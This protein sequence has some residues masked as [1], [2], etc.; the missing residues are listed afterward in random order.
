M[1]TKNPQ[2]HPSASIVPHDEKQGNPKKVRR[3]TRSR[4]PLKYNAKEDDELDE[5]RSNGE[6]PSENLE[7][8][9]ELLKDKGRAANVAAERTQNET[10]TIDAFAFGCIPFLSRFWLW[11]FAL[12]LKLTLTEKKLSFSIRYLLDFSANCFRKLIVCP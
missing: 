3:S 7:D 9:D 10:T 8:G 4:N 2:I 6:S 5:S 11:K 1:G 12:I